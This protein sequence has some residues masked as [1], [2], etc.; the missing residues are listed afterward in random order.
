MARI[1]VKLS[2]PSPLAGAGGHVVRFFRVKIC[3]LDS[4]RS[5]GGGPSRTSV[6]F[7][8]QA[9]AGRHLQSVCPTERNSQIAVS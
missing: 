2:L 6:D 9:L 4:C 1:I 8:T 7:T 5:A 3:R